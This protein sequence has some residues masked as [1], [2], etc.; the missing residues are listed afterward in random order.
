MTKISWVPP[1]P[2][3]GIMG[4]WD[5][6]VGPGVTSA[7]E[8]L[9]LLGGVGL[10]SLIGV[11]WYTQRAVLGW[12]AVQWVIVVLLALDV[13]G[14]VITN[15]TSTAKRWYHREGNGF[16][17]HMGFVLVHAVH[18]LLL[19][20]LFEVYTAQFFV[21]GYGYLVLAAGGILAA[22]LYLQR[23]VAMLL[24]CGGLLLG[25]Y[26][27]PVA[28]GLEWF[29]PFFYLKLLVNHLVKEAPFRPDVEEPV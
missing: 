12:S 3:A 28:V 2:R 11:Y 19:V 23:P 21:L 20:A 8:W 24:Y 17:G 5:K 15:A 1:K 7:E 25:F 14:G 4:S 16:W 29:L 18:L 22:P 13:I 26:L 10:F 27:L 6:F 9:Q